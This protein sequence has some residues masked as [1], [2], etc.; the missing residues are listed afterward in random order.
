[1]RIVNSFRETL[2]EQPFLT[3]NPALFI[4][5][6]DVQYDEHA[7]KGTVTSKSNIVSPKTI[8]TGDL[9]FLT[10]AQK[11]KA[12]DT[13]RMIVAQHLP[14]TTATISFKDGIPSMAPTAGNDS[15]RK[16]LSAVSTGLGYGEV[17]AGDP[18]GR[19][20]GDIS[21]IANYLD[22]LDGL[23]SSGKGSHAP[24]ETINLLLYPKLIKRTAL[25]IYRLTR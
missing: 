15:L 6:S 17:F 4:G 1:A 8:V 18:G 5:G 13:M 22:C 14:G 7:Q 23:G 12:R 9:R 25:L 3:F 16:I 2:S 20:A 21:Y 10:E 24:G 19:G 11:E